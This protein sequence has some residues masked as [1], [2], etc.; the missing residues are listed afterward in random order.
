MKAGVAVVK[1]E[2]CEGEGVRDLLDSLE[3]PISHTTQHA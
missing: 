3:H 2:E 1:K